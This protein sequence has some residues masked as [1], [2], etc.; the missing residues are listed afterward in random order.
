MPITKALYITEGLVMFEKIERLA[1]LL[2]DIGIILGIPL[3]L[4]VGSNLYSTQIEVLKAQNELLK[5]TQYDKAQSI[6]EAQKK[7]IEHERRITAESLFLINQTMKDVEHF[8]QQE[9][10][11]EFGE[12]IDPDLFEKRVQEVA[13][14]L[15]E[16]ETLLRTKSK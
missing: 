15:R 10:V 1:K 2:R 8:T 9:I 3:I 5:Q 4:I 13:S 11:E 12:D 6:V 7:L 14:N 16:L